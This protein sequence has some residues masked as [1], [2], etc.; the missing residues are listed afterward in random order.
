MECWIQNCEYDGTNKH[1][2]VS[3]PMCMFYVYAIVDMKYF[4]FRL[5]YMNT[6]NDVPNRPS[7]I[8]RITKPLKLISVYY[9]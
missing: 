6:A 2:R 4:L 9:N 7:V 3:L 1:N 5:E 8:L